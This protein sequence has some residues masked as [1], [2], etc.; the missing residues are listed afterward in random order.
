MIDS[1]LRSNRLLGTHI[2][3][4]T[5]EHA[6]HAERHIIQA[7]RQAEVGQPQ[8]LLVIEQQIGRLYITMND[9]PIMSVRQCFGRL[10]SPVGYLFG[11]YW[12]FVFGQYLAQ[13][14]AVDKL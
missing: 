11:L 7:A 13:V 5:E 2:T 10:K 3:W 14:F 8:P 12:L 6:G 1:F 9:A 4:R